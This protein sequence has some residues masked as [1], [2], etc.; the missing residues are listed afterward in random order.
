[1]SVACIPPFIINTL[2]GMLPLSPF[3]KRR[4]GLPEAKERAQVTQPGE[5]GV[6]GD[7]CWPRT[8]PTAGL[9]D[10]LPLMISFHL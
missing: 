5:A 3:Y 2:L 8:A 4:H 9:L 6:E 7:R 1:M 10:E